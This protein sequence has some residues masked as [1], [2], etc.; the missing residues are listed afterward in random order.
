[1]RSWNKPTDI[2]EPLDED[3]QADTTDEHDSD[4]DWCFEDPELTMQLHAIKRGRGWM[5]MTVI[6]TV[7]AVCAGIALVL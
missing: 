3:E 5:V 4:L 7:V 6:S 2:V 1:M